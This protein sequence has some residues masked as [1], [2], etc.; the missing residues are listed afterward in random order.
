MLI[1]AAMLAAQIP[2]NS[3][4]SAPPTSEAVVTNHRA[5]ALRLAQLAYPKEALL[6]SQPTYVWDFASSIVR[7]PQGARIEQRYP[8]FAS[9]F[10]AAAQPL[11]AK[12][13]Y[14]RLPELHR[15]A[16]EI[17][18]SDLTDSEI[19]A[20]SAF[21]SSAA[22]R[23]FATE[24]QSRVRVAT[25]IEGLASSEQTGETVANQARLAAVREAFANTSEVEKSE[26]G[27][28]I[29][30]PLGKK[31]IEVDSKIRPLA[32][33]WSEQS[34]TAIEA[35]I[36]QVTFRVMRQIAAEQAVRPRISR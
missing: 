31:A 20:M 22:G 17:Y 33:A 18:A 15:V 24:A 13:L 27:Q 7:T 16:A 28:F 12:H 26:I 34:A 30:S 25:L 2:T 9:R 14:Q 29:V 6:I 10:A 21:L 19:A 3:S 36:N 5:S 4:V 23:K 32:T 1:L 35:Q 11:T 8:S